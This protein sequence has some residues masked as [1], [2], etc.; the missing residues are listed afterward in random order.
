MTG[1]VLPGSFF[2]AE[3]L[4][5]L[6]VTDRSKQQHIP[7]AL[8]HLKEI[9]IPSFPPAR[10]SR[11]PTPEIDDD[12]R[13]PALF[14]H[15]IDPFPHYY[16][17]QVALNHVEVD[18]S[19][20]QG[21]TSMAIARVH[22][23][24]VSS[25]SAAPVVGQNLEVEVDGGAILDEEVFEEAEKLINSGDYRLESVEP[26]QS[27]KACPGDA[28]DDRLPVEPVVRTLP[29]IAIIVNTVRIQVRGGAHDQASARKTTNSVTKQQSRKKMASTNTAEQE[30]KKIC[31]S[32]ALTPS[33][34]E[35]ALLEPGTQTDA[36]RQLSHVEKIL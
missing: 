32:S 18:S 34:Q 35:L 10:P 13:P 17:P 8:S 15:A 28:S 3:P 27:A 36:K 31:M 26:G 29:S 7:H 6:E 20:S 23:E 12:L 19:T 1:S 30:K 24:E 14:D 2:V 5:P 9:E 21:L 25:P 22:E 33:E 4:L 16:E 11:P